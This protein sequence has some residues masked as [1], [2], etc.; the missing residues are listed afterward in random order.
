[1]DSRG[2]IFAPPLSR[3]GQNRSFSPIS[4]FPGLALYLLLERDIG[5]ARGKALCI[6]IRHFQPDFD[7]FLAVVEEIRKDFSGRCQLRGLP[8]WH[9]PAQ[10]FPKEIGA[11][12][13]IHFLGER[14]QSFAVPPAA[15]STRFTIQ[16]CPIAINPSSST[17]AAAVW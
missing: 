8:F 5:F 7:V 11:L 14:M 13:A 10:R 15:I 6:S 16:P 12:F 4:R 9:L 17:E 1:M 2:Y 3:Q